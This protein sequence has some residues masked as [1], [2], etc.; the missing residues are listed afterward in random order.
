M[1]RMREQLLDV[2][3]V[4]PQKQIIDGG[5]FERQMVSIMRQ[6]RQKAD[7]RA[8]DVGGEVRSTQMP[9][10]VVRQAVHALLGDVFVV[11]SRWKCDV[12]EQA[13]TTAER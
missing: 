6:A 4:I 1:T 8:A 11:G 7:E 10:L 2:D 12:P 3:L 5:G 13:L 9:E